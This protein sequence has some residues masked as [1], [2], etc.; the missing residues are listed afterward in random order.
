[1]SAC[2]ASLAEDEV[3]EECLFEEVSDGT[4]ESYG[5]PH[6]VSPLHPLYPHLRQPLPEDPG[7]EAVTGV[8]D[9]LLSL[10]VQAESDL[11]QLSSEAGTDDC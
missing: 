5:V 4:P 10:P 9:L 3:I 6:G 11:G 7:D 1:M 8:V 2:G